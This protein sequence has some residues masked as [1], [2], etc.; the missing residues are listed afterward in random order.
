M[1][2]EVFIVDGE[3]V[4]GGGGIFMMDTVKD[5]MCRVVLIDS[6]EAIINQINTVNQ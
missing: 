4:M 5:V 1:T 2:V 6:M 3:F